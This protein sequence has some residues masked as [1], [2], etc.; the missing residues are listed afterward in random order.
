VEPT[1]QR[2]SS[3]RRPPLLS[4]VLPVFNEAAVIEA[5]HRRLVE[6]LGRLP[7]LDLE[8]VYVDDGSRDDT[9]ILLDAIAMADPRV[10]LVR[11]RRNFG[12]QA[13]VT[14][15]LRQAA[16][17]AVV[18]MDA[19]LQDPPE[20]VLAMLEHW[21]AGHEVVYGIRRE[22]K[23]GLPKRVAYN[24]FYRLLSRIAD[25]EIPRDSGDFSLLDRRALEALEALPERERFVRGLRAWV[26]GPQVGLPYERAA[27][28]AGRTKYTLDRLIRLALDGIFN[29]SVRPLRAI[30]WLG[31][32]VTLLALA[33]LIAAVAGWP[34]GGLG[35]GGLALALLGGIQLLSLGV[36]GEYLGRIFAEV[37]QRP[38]YLAQRV[39]ES[40][41]GTGR[42]P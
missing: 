25:I 41:Y 14:A 22:R 21:R 13:A 39:H 4:V 28:A 9:P 23:E 19:D 8:I 6:V 11:F 29:F 37:K 30:L 33:G 26:G 36:L 2:E 3:A 16:G 32:A 18:V 1:E 20:I 31:L 5:T 27:R 42:R 24:A 15:G 34:A 35:P 38:S 10:A 17:D 40:R 7:G 12:H